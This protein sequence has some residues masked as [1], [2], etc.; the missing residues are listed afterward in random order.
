MEWRDAVGFP[1]YEVSSRG[2]VRDKETKEELFAHHFVPGWYFT[3][4]NVA[5]QTRQRPARL[6]VR[7]AFPEL[8]WDYPLNHKEETVSA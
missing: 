5:G 7:S 3:M 6:L 2:N 1:D 4:K 8:D